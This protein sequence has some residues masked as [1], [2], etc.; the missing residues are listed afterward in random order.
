MTQ[1]LGN[2][3]MLIPFDLSLQKSASGIFIPDT[4]KRPNFFFR[5]VAV[6]PGEWIRRKGKPNKWLSPEV[7]LHDRVVSRHWQND[8]A[9]RGWHA[10][11]YDQ[12]QDS[13]AW[14][15]I[16]ARHIVAVLE[17]NA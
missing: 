3:V 5:V 2:R 4:C 1:L 6:G 11:Q 7:H 9:E 16:D 12:R 17:V 10:T 14:V 13:T 15:I 8:M